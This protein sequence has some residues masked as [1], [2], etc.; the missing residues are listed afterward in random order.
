[1]RTL[2]QRLADNRSMHRCASERRCGAHRGPWSILRTPSRRV[3]RPCRNSDFAEDGDAVVYSARR[4]LA[5]SEPAFGPP[6][7]A[8]GPTGESQS[9]CPAKCAALDLAFRRFA[10]SRVT[11]AQ[12]HLRTLGRSPR[13]S[14][15]DAPLYLASRFSILMEWHCPNS[16]AKPDSRGPSAFL[17]LRGRC[18]P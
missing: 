13:A 4:A 14:A 18:E 12:Q 9:G 15:L 7:R 10:C 17:W 2:S 16:G 3:P 1:M 5:I 6:A 8:P 11:L